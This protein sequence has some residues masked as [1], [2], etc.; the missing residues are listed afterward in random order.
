MSNKKNNP[1][2]HP[3]HRPFHFGLRIITPTGSARG[4]SPQALVAF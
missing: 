3:I 4:N 2:D 1:T